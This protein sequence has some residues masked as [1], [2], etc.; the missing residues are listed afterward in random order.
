MKKHYQV[1]LSP[2]EEVRLRTMLRRGTHN[3]RVLNRAPVLLVAHEGKW[4]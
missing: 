3:S 4:D 1:H 2:E